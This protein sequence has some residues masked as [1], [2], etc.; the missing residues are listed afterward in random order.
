MTLYLRHDV[1]AVAI[2]EDLALLDLARDAYLC[3]PGGAVALEPGARDVIRSGAVADAL[4]AGGVLGPEPPAARSAPPPLPTRTLIHQPLSRAVSPRV[5]AAAVAVP[6][7]IRRARRGEGLAA[8][9]ALAEARR[10]LSRDA[11]AVEAAARQ[12]W[13]VGAWLPIEGECLVRSAMLVAFLRRMGLS[14]DWVF[15]VRLW[16]FAAHCWVQFGEVCLNDDVERLWP[17]T[18][19]YRR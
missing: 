6:A 9:L 10:P 1:H 4:L 14:A 17:Y 11:E 18:P 19:L 13:T 15:G 12:F 7:D 8:W 16:P 2:G 5:L 3:L